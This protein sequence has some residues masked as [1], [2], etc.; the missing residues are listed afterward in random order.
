MQGMEPGKSGA[1]R[2]FQFV[3]C[4]GVGGFGEVYLA[5]MSTSSGFTKMVAVKLLKDN[6]NNNPNVAERMRDEAR[7][8]GMLRHRTIIRADDLITLSGR[9]AVIMEY[10]PGCNLT[11]AI[12]P[13][14]NMDVFPHRIILSVVQNVA[15]ALDVAFHR[16]SPVSGEPLEVL[17]RDI[18]P[19]NIRLT[20][21]GEVKVL[22]FGIAR[23]DHFDREANTTE[24]QLGSLNYMAPELLTGST[25]SPASDVYSLAITFF[26]CL[27]RDRYGWAGESAEMHMSKVEKRLAEL[28]MSSS[29][30]VAGEVGQLLLQMMSY[31]PEARPSPA[32]I[33][34]RCRELYAKAP[35]EA[36]EDW[37]R[38][39][40]PRLK[41]MEETAGEESGDLTGRTLF[42]EVSTASFVDRSAMD[43]FHD[44]S[45]LALSGAGTV[46]TESAPGRSRWVEMLI[47]LV[48]LGGAGFAFFSMQSLQ[49]LA[50][51]DHPRV[52]GAKPPQAATPAPSD[53]APADGDASPAEVLAAAE[54]P[55]K[56]E[57][58][59]EEEEEFGEPVAIRIAS[60]PMGLPVFVDGRAAGATPI[61]GFMLKP[62][63]H[64]LVIKDGGKTIKK[65]IRVKA[66]GKNFWKYV[67]ADGKI[68]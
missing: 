48:L 18:K 63:R 14:C 21:D 56:A 35:G 28:D 19:G 58:E 53:V 2:Q 39:V 17:H 47:L 55:K 16:P 61:S 52:I 33:M 25:A 29:G 5:E 57:K 10:V 60:M 38:E 11:S 31:D 22:D 3:R 62:G 23:S 9:I 27:A 4:L 54:D 50:D 12:D 30:E 68:R 6:V 66:D 42:E 64:K 34:K 20:P 13:G 8:L 46:E 24:Y 1:G 26:E 36:I 49:G 44:D 32:E 59:E 51:G 65:T 40:V 7:L 45:T 41:A 43:M 67:Q 15:N 37:A